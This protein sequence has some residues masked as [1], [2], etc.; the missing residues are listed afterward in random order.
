MTRGFPLLFSAALVSGACA[1][2]TMATSG[3][4][5]SPRPAPDVYTCVRQQIKTVGFSEQSHDDAELRT[6]GRKYDEITRRPDV[7]FRRLVDRL[8][9]DIDPAAGDSATALSV[10]A[11]TAAEYMTHRGPTEQ[12]ERTSETAKRAAQVILERCTAKP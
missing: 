11:S 9:F 12:P 10:Q 5:T 6:T 3:A 2:R 4:A 8:A 1:G 7:R